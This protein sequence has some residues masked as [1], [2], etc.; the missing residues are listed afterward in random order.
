[1]P[2]IARDADTV[3]AIQTSLLKQN[4]PIT[5]FSAG[6]RARAI[7]QC[8]S[9]DVAR[10]EAQISD[11][12]LLAFVSRAVGEYLDWI[13]DLV[14]CER[15]PGES[16]DNYRYRITHRLEDAATANRAAVRLA[17]LAVDGVKDIY[18]VP[19]THGTGSFTVY[20][21][22]E[23]SLK[24]DDVLHSVQA[25]I[26]STAGYGIRGTASLPRYIKLAIDVR[27]AM[28]YAGGVSAIAPQ[29]RDAIRMHVESLGMGD[30]LIINALERDI[31]NVSP[32]IAD[33]EI[34]T[35]AIDG[36]PAL[37]QNHSLYW[38]EKFSISPND[39]MI[40]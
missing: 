30:P 37:I 14:L 11:A 24:Q 28:S 32:G 31:M 19:F 29:V 38:D 16:D 22:P 1:M 20:V 21:I 40:R 15:T 6:A 34:A 17:C 4:T 36:K 12:A 3:L 18:M 8:V 25:A 23:D 10:L 39:I 26:S 2:F 9:M 13:G 7:L 33:V 27:L 5:N 35:L